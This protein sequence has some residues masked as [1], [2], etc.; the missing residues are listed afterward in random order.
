MEME[1]FFMT[2]WKSRGLRG[3]DLEEL[4][5]LTLDFYKRQG[6]ARIDKVA[7]PVKVI[8]IDGQGMITKA[9]FEKK[10]T[11]DFIG[12]IQGTAVAFD[13]KETH[14]KSF[15]LSN[16]HDHQLAYM[17]DITKQRGLAFFIVHF[18]AFDTFHLLP[19]ETISHWFVSS[20]KKGGR[21]SIPYNAFDPELLIPRLRNHCLDFLPTLNI[22]CRKMK[23]L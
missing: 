3:S 21:K 9:F 7:T 8:D 10:S 18:K 12:V 4:I 1:C 20:Q 6:L 17:K 11:V 22:Y 14:L 13:A 5:D 16:I 19:Y 23:V 2:V 15:P